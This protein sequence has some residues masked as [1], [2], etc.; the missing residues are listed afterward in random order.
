MSGINPVSTRINSKMASSAIKGAT[1]IL[2]RQTS[3]K[4]LDLESK[5]LPETNPILNAFK[6]RNLKDIGP[7]LKEIWGRYLGARGDFC[8][9]LPPK[10]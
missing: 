10:K 4:L 7:T 3:A 6:N 8:I 2:Q 9:W 5:V 1:Q